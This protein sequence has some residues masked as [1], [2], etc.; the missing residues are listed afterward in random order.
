[1]F[2][3]TYAIAVPKLQPIVFI[4]KREVTPTKFVAAYEMSSLN[5]QGFDN[6]PPNTNTDSLR[7]HGGEGLDTIGQSR[8]SVQCHFI[9]WN[10]RL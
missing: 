5:C 8:T 9:C 4:W 2:A 7:Q 10:Q 6:Y 3:L 1:M